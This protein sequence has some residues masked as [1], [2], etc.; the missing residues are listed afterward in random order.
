MDAAFAG[1]TGFQRF[2]LELQYI[3]VRRGASEVS[4]WRAGLAGAESFTYIVRP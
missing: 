2:S 4:V 3:S 1:G